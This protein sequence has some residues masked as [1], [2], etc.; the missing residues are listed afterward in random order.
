MAVTDL[1]ADY[2][3]AASQAVLAVDLDGTLLRSDMLVETFWAALPGSLSGLPHLLSTAR[4]G[5]AALKAELVERSTVDVALL[6]YNDEVIAYIRAASAAGRQTVLITASDQRLAD[7]IA[8]YLGLFDAVHGSTATGNLKGAEKAALLDRLYGAGAWDYM[9]DHAADLEVWS[10]AAKAVTVNAPAAL[11]AKV[12]QLGIPVDHLQAERPRARDYFRALRPHQWLKNTL[13]FLPALA[14]HQLDPATLGAALL[15]FVV[16]SLVASSVY[17]LNDLLDLAADRAHPRKRNRPLAAGRIPILHGTLLAPALLV[18]GLALAV[19]LGAPLLASVLVYYV[20][21][22]A[23][24]LDLKRRLVVDICTLAGLYTIRIVAGGAACGIPLSVWLLAFS[25][26]FFFSL[27]SVKRQ[28]E[29][30]DG[31]HSG[32]KKLG[33]RGYEVGDLPIVSAMAIASGFL[34]VLVLALY[35]TSPEVDA[36]YANSAILIGICPILLYWISRMVMITHRGRMHDD[37]VVF[38]VRDRTSR[39]C[40][41]LIVAFA[42]AGTIT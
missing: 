41:G 40:L 2:A 8:T 16:F 42:I 30:V 5:R 39:I 21:T 20:L 12:A 38:A 3:P 1:A 22:T 32:K 24:S 4:Q 27:A 36:L 37:P 33:G 26:F 11:Q 29:L 6:P 9:G 14:A 31:L 25:I 19:P 13:V 34:S 35:L 10:R 23:Y 18:T 17:L 15:T 7:R 28:A